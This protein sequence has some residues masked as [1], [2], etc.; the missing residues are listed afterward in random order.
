MS[1]NII[2]IGLKQQSGDI[3]KEEIQKIYSKLIP[4]SKTLKCTNQI[5]RKLKTLTE[6]PKYLDG[7]KIFRKSTT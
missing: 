3:L 1:L 7:Y 2:I 6:N 5:S 4:I